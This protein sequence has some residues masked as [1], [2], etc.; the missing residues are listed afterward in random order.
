MKKNNILRKILLLAIALTLIYSFLGDYPTSIGLDKLAYIT[1]IG[2]DVGE[3]EN[4][5]ISFQ[6]SSVHS[7][8]FDPSSEGSSG[9][10]SSSGSSTS[11]GR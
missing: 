5:K 2:V 9:S 3:I 11:S 4:Y 1:A 7:S 8:S 6:L 10:G